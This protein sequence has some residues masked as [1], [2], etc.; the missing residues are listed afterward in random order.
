MRFLVR[1]CLD[2]HCRHR[3]V[4][5]VCWSRRR[6]VN[7]LRHDDRAHFFSTDLVG[8]E[9]VVFA[10]VAMMKKEIYSWTAISAG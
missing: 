7:W 3:G 2:H 8:G 4:P 9:D 6:G 1:C 5:Q 10:S